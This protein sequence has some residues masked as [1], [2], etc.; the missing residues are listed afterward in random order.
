MWELNSGESDNTRRHETAETSSTTSLDS[1]V[2]RLLYYS[3]DEAPPLLSVLV[4]RHILVALVGHGPGA[5]LIHWFL[6]VM[7]I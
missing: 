7:V 3:F 6:E 5:E 4:K 2:Q 1:Y